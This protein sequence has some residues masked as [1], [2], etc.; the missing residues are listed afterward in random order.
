MDSSGLVAIPETTSGLAS[1]THPTGATALAVLVAGGKAALTSPPHGL[2]QWALVGLSG[3]L[4]AYG[5]VAPKA[6]TK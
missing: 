6:V 2:L 5:A 1:V 4:A 3:V